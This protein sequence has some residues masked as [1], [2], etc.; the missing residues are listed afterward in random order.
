MK[1]PITGHEMP[2]L[3][4]PQSDAPRPDEVVQREYAHTQ[5][6][7]GL[8]YLERSYE[9][10]ESFPFCASLP[11]VMPVI[12]NSDFSQFIQTI[13]ST[14]VCDLI[15]VDAY[16]GSGIVGLI[17]IDSMPLTVFDNVWNAP[18]PAA[19]L[20]LPPSG[21]VP[22]LYSIR[23][24]RAKHRVQIMPYAYT[25]PGGANRFTGLVIFGN[26]KGEVISNV[27]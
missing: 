22:Y 12:N 18:A 19:W 21:S 14:V 3:I 26:S 17:S 1:N 24:P 15:T 20:I 4:I 8:S 16:V 27:R 2:P 10:I 11:S 6:G 23:V 9:G 13:E 25:T 5:G 7:F